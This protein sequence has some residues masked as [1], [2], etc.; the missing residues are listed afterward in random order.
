[1]F[2]HALFIRG[3]LNPARDFSPRIFTAIVGYGREVFSS[4]LGHKYTWFLVPLFAPYIG[5]IVGTLTFALFIGVHLDDE[6]KTSYSSTEIEQYTHSVQKDRKIKLANFD[7]YTDDDMIEDYG[8]TIYPK[9][10]NIAAV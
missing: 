8:E 7:E 10:Q 9:E 4:N 5:A 3:P 1:M 2:F 6:K